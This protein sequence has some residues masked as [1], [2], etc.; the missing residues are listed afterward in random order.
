LVENDLVDEYSLLLYPVVLGSGKGIFPEGLRINLKL[1]ET[2]VFP[3]GVVL[4]RYQPD[5]AA[6]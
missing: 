1:I 4:H 5:Q 2:H 6:K 3:S